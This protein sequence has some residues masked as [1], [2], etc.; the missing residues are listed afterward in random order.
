MFHS[1][2]RREFLHQSALAA[3]ASLALPGLSLANKPA[4]KSKRPRVAAIF[5]VLRFRS[6]AYNIL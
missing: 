3:G 6:H 4:E 5:T 1:S 2:T